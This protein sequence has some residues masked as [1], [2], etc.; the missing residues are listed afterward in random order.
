MVLSQPPPPTTLSGLGSQTLPL[1]LLFSLSY[2]FIHW[3]YSACSYIF[4]CF[5]AFGLLI[6]PMMEAVSTSEASV[7][8]YDTTWCN[9][10][11]DSHLHRH[12]FMIRHFN[13]TYKGLR[14]SLCFLLLKFKDCQGK[15]LY[16]ASDYRY[17]L[18]GTN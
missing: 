4:T 17:S 12:Y 14:L 9:V 15:Y 11:E 2:H 1:V 13:T 18:M 8:F 16:I 7:N 5:F 6:T 10:A 3:S